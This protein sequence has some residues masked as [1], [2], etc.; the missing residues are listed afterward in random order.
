ME[1]RLRGFELTTDVRKKLKNKRYLQREL[2]SGRSAQE[3]LEFEDHS[4]AKFYA[5][6]CLLFDH[7]KYEDAANAFLFLITL[8]PQNFDY[9]L[10]LGM[11][12]QMDE[13][14]DE[15]V[16]AYEMAAYLQLDSPAPYFYLAKCYFAMHDRE[17]ALEAIDLAIE[18]SGNH[19]EYRELKQLAK[20]A[21][22][23]LK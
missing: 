18:Y 16:D 20:Q 14:I 3:I 12:A 5:A 7:G 8:N 6:A 4:M 2:A 19:R 15:A 1:D 22:K 23:L 10:G 21:K 17:S 9:W 11:S 13:K